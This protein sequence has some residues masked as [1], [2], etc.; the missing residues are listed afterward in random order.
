MKSIAQNYTQMTGIIHWIRIGL[1]KI[2]LN[3]W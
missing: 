2:M 1:Q 3:N